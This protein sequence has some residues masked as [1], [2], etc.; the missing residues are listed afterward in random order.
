MTGEVLVEHQ[1][2]GTD[3]IAGMSIPT[4]KD[5]TRTSTSS[6]DGVAGPGI[7]EGNQVEQVSL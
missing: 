3:H 1:E 4:S 2:R 7:G 5:I 6:E